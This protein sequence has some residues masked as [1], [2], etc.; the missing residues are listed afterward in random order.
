MEAITKE[1]QPVVMNVLGTIAHHKVLEYLLR[2]HSLW[3]VSSLL[4]NKVPIP[5]LGT[6][7]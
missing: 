3:Q 4:L 6:L 7:V 1:K 5:I 2:L